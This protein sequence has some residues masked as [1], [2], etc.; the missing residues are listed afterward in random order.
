MD[1][2]SYDFSEFERREGCIPCES[3]FAGQVSSLKGKLMSPDLIAMDQREYVVI[4]SEEAELKALQNKEWNAR[5]PYISGYLIALVA[6]IV[7]VVAGNDCNNSPI[8]VFSGFSGVFF[9]IKLIGSGGASTEQ[10]NKIRDI[11]DNRLARLRNKVE[12]LEDKMLTANEF[13]DEFRSAKDFFKTKYD[14]YLGQRNRPIT[15]VTQHTN[16][17]PIYTKA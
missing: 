2:E 15:N 6:S 4:K 12:V 10:Y 3:L 5:I 17:Y 1:I 11:D 14:I 13:K 16:V 9:L 8:S 7:G